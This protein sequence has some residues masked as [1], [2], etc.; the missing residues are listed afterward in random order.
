MVVKSS[1]LSGSS[2]VVADETCTYTQCP[3]APTTAT[4]YRQETRVTAVGLPFFASQF[5]R[6]SVASLQ[7]TSKQGVAVIETLCQRI[8]THGAPSLLS[9]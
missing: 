4:H 1:N 7:S 8:Q 2:L 5:E 6:Y 3:I 9:L